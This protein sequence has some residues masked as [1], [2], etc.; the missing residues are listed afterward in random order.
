MKSLNYLKARVLV[1]VKTYPMPSSKYGELVCTAGLLD[2]SKWVRIYPVSLA[3][4]SD[5][6]GYP[7]YGWIELD[8]V[9]NTR[10]FRPESYRPNQG[11]DEQIRIC[12]K[13]GTANGWAARKGCVLKEVFASVDELIRIAKGPEQRSLATVKPK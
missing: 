13:V 7:K 11:I 1:T 10:D 8:L 2:G 3:F 6:R 12:G 5:D 9:R 4:L